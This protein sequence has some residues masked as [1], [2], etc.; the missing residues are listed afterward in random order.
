MFT[1][2]LLLSSL[3]ANIYWSPLFFTIYL[4]C[5]VHNNKVALSLPRTKLQE[6]RN[7]ARSIQAQV[8]CVSDAYCLWTQV[9]LLEQ[10]NAYGKSCITTSTGYLLYNLYFLAISDD[11]S[12]SQGAGWSLPHLLTLV[13]V[14]IWLSFRDCISRS[15]VILWTQHIIFG[16]CIA[17]WP[18]QQSW[19]NLCDPVAIPKIPLVILWPR[20][21]PVMSINMSQPAL[22]TSLVCGCGWLGR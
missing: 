17:L 10:G 22:G 2:Q 19:K 13:T 7:K 6:L 3:S 12:G 9:Q 4:G 21:T 15:S 1:S 14:L 18:L 8:S 5:K 20:L 16:L 11:I